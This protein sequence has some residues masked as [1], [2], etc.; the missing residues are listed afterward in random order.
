MAFALTAFECRGIDIAGPNLKRGLQQVC[1]TITGTSSDVDLDIGD[2][3][4]TFWSAADDSSLGAA[5]LLDMTNVVAQSAACLD[6][7][8]PQLLD[9]VQVASLTTSGQYTV[10]LS[11][12]VCPNLAF[13]AADG[14]TAY[15]IVLTFELNDG[16]FPLVKS[17]G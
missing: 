13:N 1:L 14:E 7:Q 3:D 10:D 11:D 17:Y 16:I 5:A 2:L 9:R 6:I 4:G 8:S 12:S 15:Y